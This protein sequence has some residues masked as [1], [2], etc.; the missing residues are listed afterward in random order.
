MIT[1]PMGDI[2]D[3][4]REPSDAHSSA[5][6]PSTAISPGSTFVLSIGGS[7]VCD[8]GPNAPAISKLAM[9]VDE[10]HNEGKKV[11]VVVGGGKT[12]RDYIAAAKALGANNFLL[13]MAAIKATRQNAQLLIDSM[14]NSY[15]EVL[16]DI[17]KARDVIMR[18]KVPVFGG[19]IPGFTTDTVAAL[20]AEFLGGTFVNV[21][22]V[23]GVYNL[24][25]KKSRSAKRYE[26]MSY[27][28]L[29]RLIFGSDQRRP[30]ENVVL[31]LFTCMIL[32]R[33]KIKA[34]VVS[35]SDINNV[36]AAIHGESF[37]GTVIEEATTETEASEADV[38]PI[39]Y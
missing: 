37:E 5:Y 17:I 23:D 6:S 31:D 39:E 19:L 34:I 28:T 1:I 26:K 22:N 36:K 27:N 25:P 38:E 32:R 18:G 4:F 14:Q 24:D 11:A 35:A 9:L 16:T 2:F 21:S 12:A 33:S 15:P 29:L 20:V 30:G 13:D 8:K 3:M 10:L 7:V